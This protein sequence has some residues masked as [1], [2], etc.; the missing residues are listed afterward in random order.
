MAGKPPGRSGDGA[1]PNV[2]GPNAQRIIR[3]ASLRVG[4]AV[5]GGAITYA[6]T[7]SEGQGVLVFGCMALA[8]A[9]LVRPRY[10]LHLMR[11]ASVAV[12][13]VGP[14]LG[15]LGAIVISELTR[16]I[17]PLTIEELIAPVLGAWMVVAIGV[18]LVRRF[19]RG[20]GVRLAVVGTAE[21]MSSLSTEIESTGLTGYSVIGC[22]TP[23]RRSQ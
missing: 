20:R 8:L 2:T 1:R 22:I 19:H 5:A 3:L 23:D 13:L 21:F 15:A 14:V 10:P 17:S 4:P 6:H 18:W 7:R 11:V 12:Y 16:S 9:L